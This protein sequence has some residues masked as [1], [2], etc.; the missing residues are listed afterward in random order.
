MDIDTLGLL[1]APFAAGLLVL[2]THV[3]LG[4]EVLRRGIIFIDLAVAQVAALGVIAAGLLHFEDYGGGLG[5]QLAAG[6]AALL[7][8]ALLTWTERR[9]P[10]IQ[11]ALIGLLF[12]LAATIGILLL[13]SNPHGGERLRDLLVGQILWVNWSQLMPVAILYLGLLAVWNF[14]PVLGATH[15]FSFYALFAIAVTAS[16]Q[17]VGVYLVFAS[18]IAPAVA[19]LRFTGRRRLISAFVFGML[20]YAAG[21]LISLAFDLPAGATIVAVLVVAALGGI[22]GRRR[23]S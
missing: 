19:S 7:A 12:V 1:A 18:L 14:F 13:A 10:E 6:G 3:P 17:L 20:A 9:W 4:V 16:V 23:S 21:L 11:E 2:A 15:R 8:A 22:L 5:A